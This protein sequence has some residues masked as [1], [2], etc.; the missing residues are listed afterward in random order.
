MRPARHVPTEP[1]DAVRANAGVA[2]WVD[3]GIA[4]AALTRAT[5]IGRAAVTITAAGAG[6]LLVESPARLMALIGSVVLT[7]IAAVAALTRWPA[8][9]R[10]PATIVVA[11]FAGLVGVL[12]LSGG[13]IAFFCYAAGCAAM[14]GALLGLR[15]LPAWV[16]HAALG[17]VVAAQLLAS[18]RPDAQVAVFI[19]AFPA[20][21]VVSGVGVAMARGVLERHMRLIVRMVGSAQRSAAASERTRLARE[22]H[23]SVAKTLRGISFAALALPSS[24]RRHPDLAARLAGTVSAGAEAASIQ[25]RELVTGLRLDNPDEAFM[26]TIVRQCRTWSH[27]CGVAVRLTIGPVEPDIAVRYELSRILR[28]A[29]TNVERHAQARSVTVTLTQSGDQA[30]LIVADDGWGMPR[31]PRG[32][33]SGSFG[34]VGMAE[35]AKGVGGTLQVGPT[36]TGGTQVVATV[37]I[38]GVA[39]GDPVTGDSGGGGLD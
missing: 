26:H 34:I 3:P 17:Y 32:P 24:L 29:L 31:E 35:R 12:A 6:L 39:T 33:H 16:A 14:A 19:V 1:S 5:L 25:A 15:A 28:E 11:D 30:H 2:D 8:M 22:L 13:G 23:D 7:T 20:A 38:H 21:A 4:S 36:Q 9:V 27:A 10:W 37:P 18:A